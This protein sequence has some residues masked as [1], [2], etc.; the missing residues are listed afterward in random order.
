MYGE[1]D[2]IAFMQVQ[3]LMHRIHHLVAATHDVHGL[4]PSR[5]HTLKLC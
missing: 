1:L 2:A 4:L 3:V 5:Q